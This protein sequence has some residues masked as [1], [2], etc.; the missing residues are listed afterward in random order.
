MEPMSGLPAMPICGHTSVTTVYRKMIVA[1][2][3]SCCGVLFAGGETKPTV[4]EA[5]PETVYNLGSGITPPRVVKQVPP[6]FSGVNF[7]RDGNVIVGLFV[8][9]EGVPKQVT[10]IHGLDPR[11]DQSVLDAVKQ[12]R[13]SPAKKRAEPVAVRLTVSCVFMTSDAP[14]QRGTSSSRITERPG[15]ASTSGLDGV[16]VFCSGL[17][18]A[19]R[20]SFGGR[21]SGSSSHTLRPG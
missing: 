9:V 12:W 15:L 6:S 1:I 14:G 2:L 18:L 16:G 17:A 8:S 10:I 13:F 11:T 5:G 21:A 19:Y 7:R 4:T 3:L 20:A